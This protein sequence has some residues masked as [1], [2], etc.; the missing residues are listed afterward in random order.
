[1]RSY[2]S[3]K[4]HSPRKGAT[5]AG[6]SR[7]EGPVGCRSTELSPEQ[8]ELALAVVRQNHQAADTDL[9]VAARLEGALSADA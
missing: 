5:N 8:E 2:R 7:R 9:G 3:S 4:P 6:D 1:M